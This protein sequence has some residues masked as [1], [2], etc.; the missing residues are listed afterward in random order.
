MKVIFR[1]LIF[2]CISPFLVLFLQCAFC[3]LYQKA[4]LRNIS[5]M[6]M[7][8]PSSVLGMGELGLLSTLSTQVMGKPR[9]KSAVA[10]TNLRGTIIWKLVMFAS[11]N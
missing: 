8:M 11:L 1:V 10:G 7:V 3:S 4:L 6:I 2:F 9:H 5:R